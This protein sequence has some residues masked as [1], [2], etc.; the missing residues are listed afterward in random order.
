MIAVVGSINVDLSAQ[1]LRH[2]RPGETLHGRGGQ[3][4]PG[5]KGANQAVAA[6]KLGGSVQMIGAVGTDA[7]AEV[8]LSGLRAAGVGL[9]G[10]RVVEGPTGLAIVTVAE[11]GE[12]TIVVIAGANDAVDA[13]Q[14][15]ASREVLERAAIVVCQGEIPRDGIEA[16]PAL[17]RGR[18]LH[19]PAPVMELDPAVLLA[20]N[21]L[22]VNEHEAALVLAQLTPA[23]G[24]PQQ[25][26]QIATALRETGIAS[27]VLTLGAQGSLVADADGLHPIPAAPVTAVDTT[28]AGDAFIGA[29][30]VGLARGES[31]P[32]AAHF[33][34]RV[35]AFAATGHG[36]QPSY[37]GAGAQL[38]ELAGA[39]A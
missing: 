26:E 39:T 16:L 19:N 20:S 29:L 7:Q 24:T 5:G 11:D 12:N 2:P 3:M 23:A 28:G 18:F 35:G 13:A 30:A 6:A 10:V 9:G 17:V 15:A 31:L 27:V 8:G 25:P 22:V 14:V 37:P 4:M 32:E 21:P 38:P 1:V 33:A 34:S 36:A